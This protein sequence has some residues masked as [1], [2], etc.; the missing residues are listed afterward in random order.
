MC[1]LVLLVSSARGQIC[2][3]GKPAPDCKFFGVTEIGLGFRLGDEGGLDKGWLASEL[4][5]MRNVGPRYAVGGTTY[6]LYDTGASDFR[7]GLKLRGRRWLRR[8]LSLNVSGG[9]LLL[10]GIYGEELPGYAGHIDLNYKDLVAAYV[11]CDVIRRESADERVVWHAG[12]RTG[13]H[14]GSSLTAVG[15]GLVFL[16]LYAIATAP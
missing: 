7:A 12:V 13:G 10:S 5:L 6:I 9:L 4:G 14:I 11:G 1:L 3:R 16:A 2:F 8:D 15:V